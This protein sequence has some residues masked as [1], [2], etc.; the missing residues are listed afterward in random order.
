MARPPCAPLLLRSLRADLVLLADR[1][2]G[3][4]LVA[5]QIARGQG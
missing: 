4:G 5:A 2:F 1:N 3:V